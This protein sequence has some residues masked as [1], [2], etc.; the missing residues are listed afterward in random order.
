MVT[1]NKNYFAS[2]VLIFIIEV[3]IALFMHDNFVRPYLGDV[4]VVILIYCFLKSFLKL[5]VLT[6]SVAVLLFAFGI[7]FLQFINIVETLN[8]ESSKAARTVIGTSFSWIDLLTYVVGIS[9]VIAAEKHLFNKEI[10][11]LSENV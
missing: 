4:L 8:L 6:V 3:L 7:E 5:P 10:K 2:A 9:I 11:A 1:F